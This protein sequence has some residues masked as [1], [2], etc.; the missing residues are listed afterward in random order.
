M[1]TASA[2]A[3]ARVTVTGM[4]Q[5]LAALAR[6]KEKIAAP[7][8][9]RLELT[10][11][12]SPARLARWQS[13]FKNEAGRR[14]LLCLADE[15]SIYDLPAS[16][17]PSAP[18]PGEQEKTA[19]LER[20][21]QYVRTMRPSL[22]NFSALRRTDSYE[23][24]TLDQLRAEER[25]LQFL[26]LTQKKLGFRTLGMVDSSR[27]L[28]FDGS[29]GELV[30]YRD[31]SEE[32][33][34][35][36]S[37]GKSRGLEARSFE[38]AGEFG[39]I[40]SLVD[41]DTVTGSVVWNHWEQGPSGLLAVYRYSVPAGDSHFTIEVPAE[42]FPGVTFAQNPAYHGEIAI[43]PASGSVLRIAVETDA[44]K[45]EMPADVVVEY[46]PVEIGGKDYIC[47]VHAVAFS[48]VADR[49]GQTARIFINDTVFTE[50]HLFRSEMR[51]LP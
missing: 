1:A 30:T 49:P 10:E 9:A 40:L 31:G 44:A 18:P 48:Q 26:E 5:V 2:L 23:I 14:I 47:P 7:Q 27:Q 11:R 19:I 32:Q 43:D 41:R 12:V 3:Q 34:T 46:G 42:S 29:S 50:Y 45:G 36:E 51:I 33:S 21:R 22:P 24:S 35:P 17:L 20:A 28:I 39:P 6:Q 15:S 4:E 25:Q 38:S 16:E 8:L 37:H 13:R